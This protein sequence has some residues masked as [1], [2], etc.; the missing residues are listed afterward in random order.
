MNANTTE[1]ARFIVMTAATTPS[2]S[3]WGTY[4]RIAVVELETGFEGA[5]K[6]ISERAKGLKAIV[7]TWE[8]CNVGKTAKCAYQVAL[9]EAEEMAANLNK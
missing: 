2:A 1:T 8:N 3:C 4:R 9:T 5:P 7:S 6:M